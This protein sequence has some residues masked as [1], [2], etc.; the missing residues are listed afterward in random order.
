MVFKQ[1]YNVKNAKFKVIALLVNRFPPFFLFDKHP[2]VYQQLELTFIIWV[3]S[4]YIKD[5]IYL[6]SVSYLNSPH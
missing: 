3:L 1:E 2:P 6:T 5:V 4:S